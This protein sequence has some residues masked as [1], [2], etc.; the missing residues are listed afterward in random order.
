MS[1]LQETEEE[2][3]KLTTISNNQVNSENETFYQ[4]TTF[5][6]KNWNHDKF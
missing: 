5:N 6:K 4:T 1:N 2:K 3:N